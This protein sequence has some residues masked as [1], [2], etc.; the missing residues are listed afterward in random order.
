MITET[1]GGTLILSAT[2][3]SFTNGSQFLVNGSSLVAVGQN[4]TGSV[5]A[6]GPLGGA[7]ITLNNGTLVLAVASTSAA[8]TF[9]MVSGNAVTLSGTLDTI[10]AAA[11]PGGAPAVANG[12][13]VLAGCSPIAIAANQTLSLGVSNGY[14]MNVG[15]VFSNS[16]SIVAGLGNIS[17]AGSNLSSSSGTL[18]A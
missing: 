5:P 4:Y 13:I 10:L 3:G 18:G 7:A 11:G 12:T 6:S 9:D 1:G 2:S 17:L 15:T 8:A 16:G 14:T